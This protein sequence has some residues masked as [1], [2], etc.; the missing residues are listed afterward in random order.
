MKNTAI[1]IFVLG[2]LLKMYTSFNFVT[3][4]KVVDI[5]QFEIMA[6]KNNY[7]DWS[8]LFGLGMMIIGAGLF[9]FGPKSKTIQL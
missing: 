2:M 1:V 9:F 6:D 4:E 3:R 5:G 7:Y 8:P